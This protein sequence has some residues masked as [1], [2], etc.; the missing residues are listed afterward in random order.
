[1]LAKK[2][3]ETVFFNWQNNPGFKDKIFKIGKA[4]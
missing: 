2:I 3:F 1:M 4:D